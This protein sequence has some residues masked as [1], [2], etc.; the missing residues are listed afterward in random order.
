MFKC[1]DET[2]GKWAVFRERLSNSTRSEPRGPN[3]KKKV[4]VRQLCPALPSFASRKCCAMHR[5]PVWGSCTAAMVLV[6]K[7]WSGPFAVGEL[8]LGFYFVP[9][10]TGKR[11]NLSEESYT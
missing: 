10:Q 3:A 2:H 11:A 4:S 5:W 1:C 9:S 6:V 8:K 7:V